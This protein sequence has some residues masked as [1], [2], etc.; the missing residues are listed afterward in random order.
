MLRSNY[1]VHLL[2][3]LC[4]FVMFSCGSLRKLSFSSIDALGVEYN[5]TKPIVFNSSVGLKFYA[6]VGEKQIDISNRETLTVSLPEGM[7]YDKAAKQLMINRYAKSFNENQIEIQITY[8][9]PENLAQKYQEKFILPIAINQ[10]MVIDYSGNVGEN[11]RN[12]ITRNSRLMGRDGAH[13]EN[14]VHGGHGTDATAV[15]VYFWKENQYLYAVSVNMENSEKGFHKTLNQENIKVLANGGR[16]GNG[17]NGANGGDGGKGSVSSR[18][19]PG[20]AGNGGIG[21]DGGNGGNGAEIIVY[22]HDPS[23]VKL[24]PQVKIDNSAGAGGSAGRGGERGK[25]GEPDAGQ[26]SAN[27]GSNGING[28]DGMPGKSGASPVIQALA[29]DIKAIQL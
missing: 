16:G 29:F 10:P 26:R 8:A 27:S 19:Y 21:G 28:L 2:S 13:G 12:G 17:G 14:G 4:V 7:H 6:N 11:G 23:A 20:N 25:P 5:E 24:L 18:K 15:E 9:N 3:V 1:L 22:F